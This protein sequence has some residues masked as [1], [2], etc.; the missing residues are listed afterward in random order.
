MQVSPGGRTD[1]WVVTPSSVVGVT[2][3]DEAQFLI[4][5]K[6]GIRNLLLLMDVAPGLERW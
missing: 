2:N 6:L 4:R 3:L 5:P 1:E